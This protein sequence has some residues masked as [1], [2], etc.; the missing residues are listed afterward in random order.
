MGNVKSLRVRG[1]TSLESVVGIALVGLVGLGSFGVLGEGEGRAIAGDASASSPT[2]ASMVTSQQAALLPA[3]AVDALAT[4]GKLGDEVV[5]V[6]A[7]AGNEVSAVVPTAPGLGSQL[8]SFVRRVRSIRLEDIGGDARG[9]LRFGITLSNPGIP[10]IAIS[11][12]DD[13]AITG[14]SGRDTKSLRD[15]DAKLLVRKGEF[16]VGKSSLSSRVDEALREAAAGLVDFFTTERN[17]NVTTVSIT[18]GRQGSAAVVET[19]GRAGAGQRVKPIAFQDFVTELNESRTAQAVDEEWRASA[20][21]GLPAV[22]QVLK[23]VGRFGQRLEEGG[24]VAMFKG[25]MLRGFRSLQP[26]RV[27]VSFEPGEPRSLSV[28]FVGKPV[29]RDKSFQSPTIRLVR[30]RYGDSY[31]GEILRV[32]GVSVWGTTTP[33]AF[34]GDVSDFEGLEKAVASLRFGR[35]AG[36]SEVTLEFIAD[37]NGGFRIEGGELK[38]SSG[39]FETFQRG[40]LPGF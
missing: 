28:S 26:E 39:T 35:D 7:A 32:D 21:A 23:E 10:E 18:G 36:V 4:T 38:T 11:L 2:V 34:A 16:R 12:R 25:D 30:K 31:N 19:I 40:V 3:G 33:E 15:W 37:G 14:Q 5:R 17:A 24:L 8:E 9:D 20:R 6:A 27:K 1:G 29:Q 13:T 22:D